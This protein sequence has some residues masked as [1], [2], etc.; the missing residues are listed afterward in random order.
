VAEQKKTSGWLIGCVIAVAVFG[1]FALLVGGRVAWAGWK[2]WQ[3][4]DVQRGVA[5]AG[6][7]MNLAREAQTAPGTAEVRAAGCTQAMAVTPEA[8]RRFV[9][10]TVP[11][12]GAA[13]RIPTHPMVFCALARRDSERAPGCPDV[14]R[15]YARGASPSPTRIA[16]QVSVQGEQ[17]PRCQGVFA[18]DGQAAGEL[19][20][21]H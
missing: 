8:L 6:G 3:N 21:A 18:P 11:D 20:P 17:S 4:P 19:D 1:L 15:A 13:S 2:V 14:A 16:V 7:A 9:E 5:I 12:A 10:L